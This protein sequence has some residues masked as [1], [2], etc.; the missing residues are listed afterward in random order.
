MLGDLPLFK[1]RTTPSP[2]NPLLCKGK[3]RLNI[4]TLF[5]T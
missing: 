5:L 4:K 3:D 2:V 1:H